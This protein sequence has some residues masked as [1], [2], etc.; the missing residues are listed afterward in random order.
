MRHQA[1]LQKKKI[2]LPALAE[3][4]ASATDTIHEKV[5]VVDVRCSRRA[6]MTGGFYITVDGQLFGPFSRVR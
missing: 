6:L 4:A 2:E 1:A 5:F 3:L